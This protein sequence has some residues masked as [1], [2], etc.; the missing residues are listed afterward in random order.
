MIK[1][2]K[3]KIK[4]KDVSPVDT[5][6]LASHEMED[7]RKSNLREENEEDDASPA[8]AIVSRG[9]PNLTC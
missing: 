7:W 3:R 4:G 9:T 6:K 1:K 8:H 5:L 2:K